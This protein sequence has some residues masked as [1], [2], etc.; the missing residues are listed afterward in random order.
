MTSSLDRRVN[1][2]RPDLAAAHLR[3]LAS[4]GR[5]AEGQAMT[6]M[7]ASAP[8]RREP[9]DD[10]PLDTQVLHGESLTV[11]DVVDGW[12]WCQLAADF[13]VGYV[14]VDALNDPPDHRAT[15]RIAV[16]RSFVY[17]GPSIKLPPRMHLPLGAEVA[18]A[19]QD[20]A[21]AVLADG[22]HV[23]ARHLVPLVENVA[24]FVSVAE[25]FVHVPYL[26]G[27]KTGLGLDCS[28]LAQ[29]SLRMAGI[30]A[31][32]DSDMQEREVGEPVVDW[33]APGALRRGD[34]IFW[35]GHVGIMT[36]AATL[37]HANGHAMLVT[38]EPLA[39]ARTR[40]LSGSFGAITSVRRLRQYPASTSTT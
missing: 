36:D 4:A 23:F 38:A 6:C 22:G 32:R 16:P 9:R 1:A 31:P 11:Y 24:D 28:G 26:W 3:G 14:P 33:Q 17:P 20:G 30:A 7:A 35:K 10:A 29:I 5:Y 40:I 8:L 19:G 15:H 34:L 18:V 12:A 13:Y 27:G 2:L 39:V 21:F 37:L 25:Q